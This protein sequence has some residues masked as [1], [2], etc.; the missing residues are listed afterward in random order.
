MTR[1]RRAPLTDFT[2][3]AGK[4]QGHHLAVPVVPVE[5]LHGDAQLR[6]VLRVFVRNLTDTLGQEQGIVQGDPYFPPAPLV[7]RILQPRTLGVGF[8]YAY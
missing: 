7:M 6:V 4:L 3:P 5:R 2:E 8:D 1:G